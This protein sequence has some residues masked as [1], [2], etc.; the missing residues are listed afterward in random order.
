MYGIHYFL[1]ASRKST[2]QLKS[3]AS[4]PCVTELTHGTATLAEELP[5]LFYQTTGP[6]DNSLP[7]SGVT[8]LV[9]RLKN[10]FNKVLFS[11]PILHSRK[12]EKTVH[13]AIL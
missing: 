13:S 5:V 6:P 7:L 9:D 10:S 11:A 8:R 2:H 4:A 3:T 12:A 1:A